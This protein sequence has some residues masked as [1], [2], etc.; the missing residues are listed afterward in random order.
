MHISTPTWNL[1]LFF[2]GTAGA[3]IIA[4]AAAATTTKQHCAPVHYTQYLGRKP[5]S[6][7]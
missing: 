7:G 2:I 5:I 1:F 3:A 4:T 6:T